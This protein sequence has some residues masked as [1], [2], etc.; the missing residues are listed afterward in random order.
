M[1]ET[2]DRRVRWWWLV[3]LIFGID[4]IA[5]WLLV[6]R[7]PAEGSPEVTFARDMAA[8]HT[9]A[10]ELAMILRDRS[11]DEELR[12]FAL[13]ILLTQQAQIGQMEGWLAVWGQPLSGPQPPMSGMGEM[14]GMA[15]R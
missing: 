5:V 13:D 10:V 9:Q 2:P 8:H 15:T 12:R 6:P 11:T 14:M 3:I 1:S 4:L 7:S